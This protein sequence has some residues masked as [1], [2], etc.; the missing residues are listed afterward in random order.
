MAQNLTD[1]SNTPQTAQS[2]KE[3][4]KAATDKRFDG[5]Q[6]A[7]MRLEGKVSEGGAGTGKGGRR[8]GGYLDRRSMAPVIYSNPKESGS[9]FMWQ[10]SVEAYMDDQNPGMRQAL[11]WA[12]EIAVEPSALHFADDMG[13]QDVDWM[14]GSSLY[15]FLIGATAGQARRF[16][17]NTGKKEKCG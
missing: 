12:R 9:L 3:I 10:D 6:Q 13:M 5:V 1:M 7:L 8:R 14:E 17:M 15:N 16:V 2:Q 4:E 11:E